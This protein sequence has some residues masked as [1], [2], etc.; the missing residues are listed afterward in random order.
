MLN[1][2]RIALHY[3]ATEQEKESHDS[4]S[5][6]ITKANRNFSHHSGEF[7]LGGEKSTIPADYGGVKDNLLRIK[8]RILCCFVVDSFAVHDQN[9]SKGDRFIRMG[10]NNLCRVER[11]RGT[12]AAL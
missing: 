11:A 9:G 5:F 12:K 7:L 6:I 8:G 3:L 10:R 2:A 1:S 4:E